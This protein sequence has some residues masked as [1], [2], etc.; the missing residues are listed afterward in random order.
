MANQPLSSDEVLERLSFAR[1][2]KE[3][4][5]ELNG[6]DLPGADPH[7][8][9]QLVQEFFFHLVGAIE[10]LAQLVNESR[11]L[12][13]DVEDA[14][15]S[16]VIRTLPQGYALQAALTAL[17]ANTRRGKPV[18]TDLYSDEGLIY[19]IWNY[20]HQVTHRRRQPFQF[21]IGIGTAID[22]GPGVRGRWRE[23]RYRRKPDP[24]TQ[25]PGRS[26]HFILDPRQPPGTRT[27]SMHS[28]PAELDRMLEFV[29]SRCEHALALI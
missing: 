14:S 13:L 17:Y 23:F 6:G 2:R 1:I 11:N 21:N 25:A 27:A 16:A 26:A 7:Y 5:L 4:L 12:G 24:G 29:S 15:A 10:V 3:Q 8:R 9:Q 28:V 22:F 19:R 18:P 20:R